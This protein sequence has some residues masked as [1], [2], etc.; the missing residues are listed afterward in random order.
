M[1]AEL[2]PGIT[3][4][5]QIRLAARQRADMEHN[6]A[7]TDAEWNVNI[8]KSYN[9]LYAKMVQAYREK[10]FFTSY[11]FT[12][13]ADTD[14][15]D[16]PQDFWK[17]FGAEIVLAPGPPTQRTPLTPFEYNSRDDFSYAGVSLY[18]MNCTQYAVIKMNTIW[19][20]P[21]P[22]AGTVINVDYAPRLV[23]PQDQPTVTL[24]SVIVGDTLIVGLE[25][26]GVPVVTTFTAAVS[27]NASNNEFKV[28]AT[29]TLTTQSLTRVI[30][31]RYGQT[32]VPLLVGSVGN[33]ATI[34]LNGPMS[35]VRWEAASNGGLSPPTMTLTPNPY[36]VP[37]PWSNTLDLLNGLDEYL[38]CD[39]ARKALIKQEK[40]TS[41]VVG[42]LREMDQRIEMETKNRDTGHAAKQGRAGRMGGGWSGQWR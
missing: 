11:Q 32:S 23:Y 7:V 39:T 10:Y 26:G 33:V 15:Y 18:G 14:K 21:F 31:F 36:V 25:Q 2:K 35:F 1:A 17:L 6:Y 38:V 20:R 34:N 16:L 37:L 9:A 27:E 5:S 19:L 13:T 42:E 28:G 40:D 12:T 29:D 24:N 30:N 3:I 22:N 8:Q 41:A 4:M